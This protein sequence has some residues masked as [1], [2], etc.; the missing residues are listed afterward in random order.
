[1]D[2]NDGSEEAIVFG[3]RPGESRHLHEKIIFTLG[4]PWSFMAG[5]FL[6][7][8][9]VLRRTHKKSGHG[10]TDHDWNRRHLPGSAVTAP[11]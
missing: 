10:G 4:A 9:R 2:K 7:S 1:M 8:W 6:S 5:L 11:I 3:V